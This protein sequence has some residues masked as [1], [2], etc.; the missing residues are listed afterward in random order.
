[1]AMQRRSTLAFALL[2]FAA[3]LVTSTGSAEAGRHKVRA[4]QTL[5]S[6]ALRYD[7]S[8]A[9][10]R[11]ANHLRGDRILVGQVLTVPA[12]G[13]RAAR[14]TDRV[15]DAAPTRRASTPSPR[16]SAPP[17]PAP[18]RVK[19]QVA[20]RA[21]QRV[22]P[23][24]EPAKRVASALPAGDSVGQPWRG[25]LRGGA[26]LSQGKGYLIRRPLRSWGTPETVAMVRDVLRDVRAEHRELHTLAIGDISQKG[27]GHI[28]EHRS[29]QSGRDIDVGFFYTKVPRGYPNSFAL[30]TGDNLDRAATWDLLVGFARTA[31]DPGGVEAIFLDLGVQGLLYEWAK[32]RG[33]DERYLDRLFQYPEGPGSSGLVRHQPHHGDHMHVRFRCPPADAACH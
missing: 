21:E 24:V 27:G 9:A 33:V 11:R 7:C 10:L 31:D 6:I 13:K 25:R 18:A 28:S 1:M 22:A 20:R 8:I 12:C 2:A 29:H 4:G 14:R 17:A 26:R 32:D 3:A 23:R 15:R 30:A 19:A 16:P 5:G